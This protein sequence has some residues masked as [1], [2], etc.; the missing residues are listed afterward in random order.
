MRQYGM[1]KGRV[2]AALA[3][4][5]AVSLLLTACSAKDD[6]SLADRVKDDKKITIGV[7][8]DQPGIGLKK[9]D[10]SVEGMDI[11]FGT[12]IAQQLGVPAKNIEWKE[13]R[14]ANREAFITN[15]TVDVVLASYSITEERK[16]KVG[17][18]GPYYVAHQDIMVRA[19]D[20]SIKSFA[21]LKGKR[22][23]QV[24]GSNSW[25]NITDGLNK[26]NQKQDVTLVPANGYD[27]CMTKLKGRTVDVVTTDDVILAGFAARSPQD[28]KVVNA[29]FTDEKYGV[30]MKKD[31]KKSCEKINAAIKKMYETGKAKE[32]LQKH[33]GATGFKFSET[34]PTFEPCS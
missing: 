31:D 20:N 3:G 12:Y 15:G 23:C 4:V 28:F 10:G 5:A 29:P 14:S 8:F 24:A 2:G 11:D 26:L 1:L 34:Q 16:K 9:P 22:V 33:F 7:K 19:N 32:V 18:A 17:F 30:G 21:D 6:S 27:E 25:K 13:T